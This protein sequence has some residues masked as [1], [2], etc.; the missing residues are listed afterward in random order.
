MTVDNP[1]VR[2]FPARG[3]NYS[4]NGRKERESG[5]VR[6][7][8]PRQVPVVTIGLLAEEDGPDLAELRQVAR[9]QIAIALE[10]LEGVAVR[11]VEQPD[12]VDP[13][14]LSTLPGAP[15]ELDQPEDPL[16]RIGG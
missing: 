6:R 11:R 14:P 12:R 16:H 1:T 2:N 3:A 4:R 15:T 5:V 9:R 10:R 7:F 8:D 13:R